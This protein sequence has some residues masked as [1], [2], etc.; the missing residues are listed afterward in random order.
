[1]EWVR[2][3]RPNSKW[4]VDLVTNVT[5]F[6]WKIRDHP[7]GRGKYLPHYL[8]E[9]RGITPLD[10]N[11]R[12]GNHDNLCFFR[13]LAPY[14]GCHTNNLERDTKHYYQQYREAG[15][16]K[17]K[18]HGVKLSELD[19]LEKLFEINIQVHS[20]APTQKHGEE[21]EEEETRPDIAATLLRRS[22]RHYESTLY[23]NLYENHFSYIKRSRQ[24]LQIFLLFS[25]RQVLERCQ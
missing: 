8:V 14:N 2:Q 10:R 18:F 21:I 17:K 23:L 16:A 19:E 11:I 4:V 24:L 22:H 1:M 9:N 13:C 25:L 3:Q 12:R 7:I 15:L 6:A 5:W 20:L